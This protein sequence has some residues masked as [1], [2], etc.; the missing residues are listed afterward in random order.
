MLDADKLVSVSMSQRAEFLIANYTDP[1]VQTQ[2]LSFKNR[3]KR[4]SGCII[5]GKTKRKNEKSGYLKVLTY[6]IALRA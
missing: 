4:F 3:L 5:L 1:K 6:E 2:R